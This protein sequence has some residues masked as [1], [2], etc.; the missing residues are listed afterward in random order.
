[1][2]IIFLIAGAILVLS[3]THPGHAQAA[4]PGPCSDPE[5][6][7]FDFWV[8]DWEVYDANTGQKAGTNRIDSILGGC[9]LQEHWESA[10]STGESY[11]TWVAREKKWH[12]TWVDSTGGFLSLDGG[13]DGGRMVLS[14]THVGRDGAEV[15]HEI[16]WELL[17]DGSVK[18]HWRASRDGGKAWQDVFAGIYRKRAR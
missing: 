9:A 15:L 1:M 16:S 17:E 2:K 10:N 4:Q 11:N 5:Y 6:R 14:G 3:S 8:G 13:L 7:Q 18:Q 12:Q